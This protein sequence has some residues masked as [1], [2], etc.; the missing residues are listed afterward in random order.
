[1][2]SGKGTILIQTQKFSELNYGDVVEIVG[3]IDE[4]LRSDPRIAGF[5][6]IPELRS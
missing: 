5:I 1:M 4:P 6:K 2:V 3:V